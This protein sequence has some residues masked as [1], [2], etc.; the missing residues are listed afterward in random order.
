[1]EQSSSR[2]I[3]EPKN[4]PSIQASYLYQQV[5]RWIVK[6]QRW[7]RIELNQAFL[8]IAMEEIEK[9]PTITLPGYI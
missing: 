8:G 7:L 9:L 6:H 5:A 4:W 2:H 3:C 1:M